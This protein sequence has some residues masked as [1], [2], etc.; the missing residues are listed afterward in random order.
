MSAVARDPQQS[1][2]R[3]P[4]QN[5]E[6]EMCVLGG[7]MLDPMGTLYGVKDGY[8]T[9]RE[10]LTR[11]AFYLDGHGI[12]FEL[13]GELYAQGIPPDSIAVLDALRSRGL[14]ERV[15]GSGVV[16]GML[17]SVATGASVEYHSQLVAEK[18]QRRNLIRG[19]THLI[20]EAYKQELAVDNLMDLA[21]STIR[22]LSMAGGK[23]GEIFTAGGMAEGMLEKFKDRVFQVEALKE[24]GKDPSELIAGLPTSFPEIDSDTGGL[25]RGELI[26]LAARPSMGKSALGLNMADHIAAQG[27][28][29][30]F[31]SLE[32]DRESLMRRLVSA[33][34]HRLLNPAC[35][36]TRSMQNPGALTPQQV[37]AVMTAHENLE[38]RHGDRL[39]IVDDCPAE[40]G[41]VIRT[42]RRL[43]REGAEIIFLDY[44][45]LIEGG[46]EGRGQRDGLNRNLEISG[47]TRRLKNLAKE[48]G[49]PVVALS[50]LSRD[51]EKGTAKPRPP[52]LSDLRESGAIEQDA[53]MVWFIWAG[54]DGWGDE[55]TVAKEAFTR[56]GHIIIAKQR[57]GPTGWRRIRFLKQA[58]RF[59]PPAE[60]GRAQ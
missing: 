30:G 29:A 55:E 38:Q 4:P 16:M 18:A 21:E 15:G 27:H 25:N 7:I 39:M 8:Q 36:D 35:V 42:A 54:S 22:H 40:I 59:L 19:C 33:E 24:A 49:V 9:A 57:N 43:L 58:S 13:M 1:N 12:I 46:G 14:L 31:I 53:D 45:Q 5:V 44:L 28:K 3:V 11:E 56:D 26:I 32:M 60:K 34:T 37:F 47:Y 51:N 20:E 23:T 48:Y 52:R 50:Q 41:S 10:L 2:E 6:L 17:N